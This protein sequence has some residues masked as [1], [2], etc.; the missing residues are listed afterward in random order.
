[1]TLNEESR[2]GTSFVEEKP[3]T[4]E[5]IKSLKRSSFAATFTPNN[6]RAPV[7]KTEGI[8]QH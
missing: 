2:D 6:I 7:S 5:F 1:L 4:K 3:L 8:L